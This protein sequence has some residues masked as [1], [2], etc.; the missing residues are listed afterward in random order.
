MLCGAPSA[1]FVAALG[2]GEPV[3][4]GP[5]TVG[6]GSEG[7][8][9]AGEQPDPGAAEATPPWRCAQ[10]SYVACGARSQASKRSVARNAASSQGELVSALEDNRPPLGFAAAPRT[11][12]ATKRGD[13]AAAEASFALGAL[14][15]SATAVAGMLGAA[16]YDCGAQTRT[17]TRRHGST[18]RLQTS[19]DD[20]CSKPRKNTRMSKLSRCGQSPSSSAQSSHSNEIS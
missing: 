14:A 12:A 13:E 20:S 3:V 6:L 10:A 8:Q 18:T 9:R 17:S 2:A 19:A 7:E 1:P 11:G 5:D 15:V 4:G 16:G